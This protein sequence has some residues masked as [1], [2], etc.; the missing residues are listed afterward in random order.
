[1]SGWKVFVLPVEGRPYRATLDRD[2]LTETLGGFPTTRSLEIYMPTG[3]RT[4]GFWTR[5]GDDRTEYTDELDE[6]HQDTTLPVNERAAAFM[7]DIV[8][9]GTVVITSTDVNEADPTRS[10][11]M[12]LAPEDLALILDEL[13][14]GPLIWSSDGTH[15]RRA[16]KGIL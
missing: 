15:R 6:H 5:S 12:D 13:G 3:T 14:E 9:Y 2:G 7:G 4:L 11:V 1:M 10:Q 8:L 16:M